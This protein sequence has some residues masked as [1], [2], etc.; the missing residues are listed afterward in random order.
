VDAFEG[1]NNLRSVTIPSSVNYIG[2]DAFAVIW[3]MPAFYF[4]GNAPT[5]GADAFWDDFN[6][7]AYF[8]PGTTGWDS[9]LG[10]LPTVLWNPVINSN[11]SGFGVRTN[12]FGFTV[13]GTANI[14]I[15]IEA[16]TNLASQVWVPLQSCTLTNGLLY[17]SDPQWT[18]YP[19]RFYRLRSP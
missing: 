17:F 4:Q 6:T 10:G 3:K 2:A 12:R 13:I 15:V 18:N 1:C 9:T 14:P 8:L 16:C 5:L 11:G 19:A 7:V